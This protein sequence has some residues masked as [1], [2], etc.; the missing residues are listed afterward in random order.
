MGLNTDWLALKSCSSLPTA[1][2][3][4]SLFLKAHGQPSPSE[5]EPFSMPRDKHQE[6]STS[7]K[8]QECLL[9]SQ[10]KL[11][12][13]TP[14]GGSQEESS[15]RPHPMWLRTLPQ[16]SQKLTCPTPFQEEQSWKALTHPRCQ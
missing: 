10:A 12:Q 6:C 13:I 15:G 3:L 8:K 1:Q 5:S 7:T 11:V 9:W 2:V 4:C 16:T 14:P